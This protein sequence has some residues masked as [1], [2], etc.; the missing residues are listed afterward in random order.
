M[1]R[2]RVT[3][4][5]KSELLK[6][7]DERID[8]EK[9]R[10]RSHAVELI[11]SEA[12]NRQPVKVLILA[13]GKGVI[14]P[15]SRTEVPKAL[16]PLG[17]KPLLEHMIERLK[18]YRLTDIVIS[19]SQASQSIK[20]Y[21][22]DGFRFGVNISY[23]EQPQGRKG[24]AQ[25]L[26]QA[27]TLFSGGT[28]LLIYGDVV[29]DIDIL[30][31]LEFHRSQKSLVGT[32]ALTSVERVSMW[33]VARVVGSKIIQFEEKPQSPKTHSHLV[34]AGMYVME[35]SIF[36]FLSPET[37]RLEKEIFPRL[38]E[39]NK[40]GGYAFDGAWFDVSSPGAAESADEYL[41]SARHGV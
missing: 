19:L 35:P 33:G 16:L 11:L 24:T 9:V 37:L 21:F 7:L 41:R 31:F 5:L 28:F 25:P 12:L 38:A 40:L 3:I 22:R 26:K 17:G 30:D 14:A 18:R 36:R 27:Q 32:M 20:D 34:N 4:T 10:N 2:E 39:E 6:S 29:A 23:L 13:G 15:G 8:G 1:S